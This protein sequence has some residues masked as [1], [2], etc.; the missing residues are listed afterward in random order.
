I[1]SPF[2]AVGGQL[3]ETSISGDLQSTLQLPLSFTSLWQTVVW[4]E[5]DASAWAWNVSPAGQFTVTEQLMFLLS[6]GATLLNGVGGH[7][8]VPSDPTRLSVMSSSAVP[9][10]MA[11]PL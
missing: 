4:P 2:F 9:V 8:T 6:F 1:V 11:V 5:T 10:L 7:S 3:F